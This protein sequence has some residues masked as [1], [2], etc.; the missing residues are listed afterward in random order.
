MTFDEANSVTI[1]QIGPDDYSRYAKVT[2]EF[3]VTSVLEVEPVAMGIGGLSLREM[4]VAH[5]YPKYDHDEDPVDW[6]GQYDLADWGIFLA[7]IDQ[8]P[9]GGAAVA[10]P[11]A[12]FIVTEGREDVAALWDIRVSPG[13]RR[14]G[15]GTALLEH[16]AEWAS[17]RGFAFLDIEAQNVNAPGC[18][19]YAKNGC[20]LVEI[21]RF[22]Y[23]RCP[24]FAHEA[25]LIWH[26]KL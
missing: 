5:P 17:E 21:R 19:F 12:G 15:V 24:E 26:L 6:A 10:P 2:P 1:K 3:A 13:F 18:R 23:A 22:G 7:T 20:E 25:M 11:T 4:P 14:R 8:C 9:V 16:C